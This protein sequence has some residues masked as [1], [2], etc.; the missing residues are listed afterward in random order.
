MAQ[1]GAAHSANTGSKHA[2]SQFSPLFMGH[3]IESLHFLMA[4]VPVLEPLSSPM[5]Q[6]WSDGQT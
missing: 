5:N 6:L 1:Q 2:P 4:V 3:G